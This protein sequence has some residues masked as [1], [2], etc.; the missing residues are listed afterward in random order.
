MEK[1]INVDIDNGTVFFAD[2]VAIIHNPTKFIVDFKSI[3]P[4]VDL[5]SK[6]FQPVVLKHNVVMMD[7]F[8]MKSFLE[9]LSNNVQNYEK[10][11]GKITE[12]KE[13]KKMRSLAGRGKKKQKADSMDVP[14]YFG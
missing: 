9:A 12:P 1:K 11:F 4:R 10:K 2:E 6:D 5:R 7:P 14:S 8:T 3:T 13:L